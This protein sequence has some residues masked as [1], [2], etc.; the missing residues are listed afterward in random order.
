VASP[1][2]LGRRARVATTG[3]GD[4]EVADV[5]AGPVPGCRVVA[6]QVSKVLDVATL[7]PATD[8]VAE[9]GSCV[10]V[11]G[12]NGSGKTTLLRLVA[13]LLAPTTGTVTIDGD[14]ADERRRSTRENV[15]AL[16]GPPAAY[17]D[18]TLADH[19]TLVDATWGR[20]AHTCA[21]RVQQALD[22]FA[23]GALGERFP[24]ELSSGQGQ[25]FRL[26][27]TWFRP[28][29]LLVLDEPEQRLDTDR[30]AMVGDLVRARCTSGTTV[31]MACHDPA[32]TAAVA[33][34]VVD[35]GRPA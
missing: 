4:A 28:A 29:R 26:A 3:E 35:V 6:D 2:A 32:L 25:L 31:L 24:H 18:L 22:T 14:P 13:G 15:A 16:I 8:L 30:R 20:N 19:L 33:D 34:G 27:L 7:L 9:P 11:R 1:V 21:N 17:R 5:S 10:V 23:L 12:P